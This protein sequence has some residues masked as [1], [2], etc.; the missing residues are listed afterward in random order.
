MKI[1]KEQLEK[2]RRKASREAEIESGI[3]QAS[4]YHKTSKKD[5][6]EKENRKKINPRKIEDL[7]LMMVV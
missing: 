6:A 3:R 4:G 5:R 7:Q 1:T 2:M